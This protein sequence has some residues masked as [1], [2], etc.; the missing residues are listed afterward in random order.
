MTSMGLGVSLEHLHSDFAQVAL[1]IPGSKN[2]GKTSFTK[3]ALVEPST[4]PSDRV[5][6]I[7]QGD[8]LFVIGGDT[9]EGRGNRQFLLLGAEEFS[10]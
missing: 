7:R 5:M 9:E 4:R 6:G 2:G 8:L 3:S 10:P 1:A